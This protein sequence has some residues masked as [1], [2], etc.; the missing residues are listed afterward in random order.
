MF[1]GAHFLAHTCQLFA[2]CLD[3]RQVI[4]NYFLF[5]IGAQSSPIMPGGATPGTP[6]A[7]QKEKAP[8]RTKLVVALYNYKAIESGDLSLEKNQE[9]E[10]IDDS[11]EHWWKVKDS[12]G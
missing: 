1:C 3:A 9:Y 8:I 11:Q 10:V 12:K 7:K 4:N 5:F 2:I 6:S